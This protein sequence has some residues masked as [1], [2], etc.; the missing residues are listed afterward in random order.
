MPLRCRLEKHSLIAVFNLRFLF[1][2]FFSWLCDL[3]LHFECLGLPRSPPL[4]FMYVL[5]I[6]CLHS[7][8]SLFLSAGMMPRS[9]TQ[10][11]WLQQKSVQ[12]LVRHG[13]LAP[14][15]RWVFVF[16][17]RLFCFTSMPRW[18][19]TALP[20]SFPCYAHFQLSVSSPSVAQVK[21]GWV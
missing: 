15:M 6:I 9:L 20:S 8:F 1:F 19:R 17:F 12:T 18:F 3:R 16:L 11:V 4:R 14:A 7:C 5:L 13:A 21:Q 10:M 2:N